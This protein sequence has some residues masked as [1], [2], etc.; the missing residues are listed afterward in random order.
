MGPRLKETE[1]VPDCV[2]VLPLLLKP[3]LKVIPIR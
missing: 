2:P 1:T 3:G